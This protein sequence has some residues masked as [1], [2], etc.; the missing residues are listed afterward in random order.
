V[1]DTRFQRLKEILAA[2]LDLPASERAAYV[3]AATEGDPSLGAEAERILAADPR[4]AP[5]LQ[6]GWIDERLRAGAL[7]SSGAA[8]STALPLATETPASIGPYRIVRPLGEG[9]MGAVYLAEQT[10]PIRRQV[11]LKL[12]K[13][14]M[15]TRE[16]IAR[17]EGERQALALMDHP[18]VAKVF[19]AGASEQGRP[20]FVMEYAPG[21]P[22][23]EFCDRER[24]PTRDRLRLFRDVCLALHHAHQKGIIHRDVKPS[25]I[26]VSTQDGRPAPIVIDFGVAK[27]T[28]QRLTERTLLTERGV[29]VG[30]PE[31]M[32][33]EQA[34]TDGQGV[35][36]TTDVYSLGALLYELLTGVLP[37]DREETRRG[38][39]ES[40]RRK[41]RDSDPPRPSDRVRTLGGAEPETAMRRATTGSGLRRQLRGDLDWIVMKAMERDRG[42]RYS[43]AS[44]LA[45]D[46]D[47]Y[48]K[49]EAVAAGPPS[50]AY[51][52]RKYARRHRAALA[53][54]F[55]LVA[56]LS[57]ALILS[58]RQRALAEQARNEAEAVTRFLVQM[59]GAA[60]PRLQGRA[61]PVG[62]VLDRASKAI[63]GGFEGQ[64]TVEAGLRTAIGSAYRALGDYP[65]ARTHLEA[66]IGLAKRG[67]GRE[68]RGTLAA[69]AELATVA[70]RQ[71]RY[72]E[73]ESLQTV[74]LEGQR[75]LLGDS[76]V[77]TLRSQANLA[78][79]VAGQGRR[80]EATRMT[81]AALEG[82]L[83]VEGEESRETLETM[84]NLAN[85]HREVGELAAA[86][87]LH[88]RVR[89]GQERLLSPEDP[90][91]LASMNALAVVYI[92]Q[93]RVAEAET[94]LH[95]TAEIRARTLGPE[96]QETLT[97][98]NNLA[99]LRFDAG[100]FEKAAEIHARVLAIRRRVLGDVHPHT[101]ISIGNLGEALTR[102][103]NPAAGEPLLFEAVRSAD[104]ALGPEH[105]ISCVTLRKYG[106]CL[107]RLGRYAE[108]ES[109]LLRAHAILAKTFGSAHERTQLARSDLAD[110]Y[111]R[112]GRRA[113]SE[114]WKRAPIP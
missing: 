87:S 92:A 106:V 31:Y 73:A 48:L 14:G 71:G 82:L 19:D 49:Y 20:Y 36:I 47:R 66:A 61:A 41:I 50:T 22:I 17:F 16:V 24:L 101:L 86:E 45:A 52:L 25:N 94:L 80:E 85:L 78:A 5:S 42:R 81:R 64:P 7:G 114:A 27:A 11:A 72:A 103:G 4:V 10:E 77:E 62:E 108:A 3:S 23:T 69:I 60:D 67:W 12:I 109:A 65:V 2:A 39:W 51:R 8:P 13:L 40:L 58:N 79:I 53:V 70:E 6:S 54:A 68:H 107:A 59:L 38:G 28:N 105:A 111:E 55:T 32:S 9:G 37:F 26:L 98:W 18:G 56:G 35:D 99:S 97:A 1:T 96:H 110:L 100:E 93:K 34:E 76:H 74:A 112:R 43:S 44:E 113:E 88:L 33:P 84:H 15:D 63:D 89:R 75:R 57:I 95:R 90:E 30:T 102:A 21:A 83:R 46:V 29:L 91:L 104:R